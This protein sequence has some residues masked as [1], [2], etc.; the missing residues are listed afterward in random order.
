M[1]EPASP[2]PPAKRDGIPW[3]LILIGVLALYGI[4]LVALNARQTKVNFV[5]WSTE[6]SLVVLLL[7]TLAVGF[8]A[9][10][11]FDAARD[12][13]KQTKAKPPE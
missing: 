7:I 5:F 13:R 8:L 6:A 12:R 11:L 10:F 1:S 2:A 4:L 3:R 9:G